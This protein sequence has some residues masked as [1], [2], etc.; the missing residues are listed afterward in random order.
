MNSYEIA[1]MHNFYGFI[2]YGNED[3]DNAITYAEKV[4]SNGKIDTKIIEDAKIIIARA[5]FETDDFETIRMSCMGSFYYLYFFQGIKNAIVNGTSGSTRF[6]TKSDFL[7]LNNIL[8]GYTLPSKF[9]DKTGLDLVNIYVS[10]DN[11]WLTSARNG[12]N[13]RTSESGNT[14]RRLYAPLS[15]FTLGVKLKF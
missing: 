2:Y 8:V 3:F 1:M 12:F 5:A 11:L 9:L 7:A 14:G 15:T 13:P 4:L 6:L 10:G